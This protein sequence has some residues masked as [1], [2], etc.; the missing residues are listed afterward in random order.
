MS[1]P[2]TIN[3]TQ[4]WRDKDFSAELF[5]TLADNEHN[6]C[7]RDFWS[8]KL[9]QVGLTVGVRRQLC[10]W[11]VNQYLPGPRVTQSDR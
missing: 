5:L 4:S 11:S 9:A 1:Q 7:G 6:S 2:R 10:S 8:L 3:Y